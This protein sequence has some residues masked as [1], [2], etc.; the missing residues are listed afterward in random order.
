MNRD[1]FP[2]NIPKYLKN[3]TLSRQELHNVYILYKALCEV[4]SQRIENYSLKNKFQ[5]IIYFELDPEDGLD[6]PSFKNGIYKIFLQSD[7]LASRIFNTID[8]N[9]SG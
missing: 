4:T 3:S 9:L 5:F 1:L 6:F 8:F 2:H 7:E